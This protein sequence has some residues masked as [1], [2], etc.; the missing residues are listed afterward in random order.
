MTLQFVYLLSR[1]KKMI[2]ILVHD[3]VVHELIDICI[4]KLSVTSINASINT[5]LGTN[6][7]VHLL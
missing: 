4:E 3:C 6:E 1:N 2:F 5:G 7:K